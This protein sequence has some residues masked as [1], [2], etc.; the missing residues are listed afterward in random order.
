MGRERLRVDEW[1]AAAVHPEADGD[2]LARVGGAEAHR[3]QMGHE[4]FARFEDLV[5]L[6]RH[7]HRQADIAAHFVGEDVEGSL[8]DTR[9]G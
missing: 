8:E 2:L 3:A 7:V 9:D 5:G 1:H 4:R 6:R